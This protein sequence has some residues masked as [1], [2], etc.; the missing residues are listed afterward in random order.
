MCMWELKYIVSFI[1]VWLI[2]PMKD[3]MLESSTKHSSTP[4]EIG[5]DSPQKTAC[6]LSI[7]DFLNIYTKKQVKHPYVFFK[8]QMKQSVS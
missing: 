3:V 8:W 2:Y 1:N 5:K 6:N 4:L 7:S